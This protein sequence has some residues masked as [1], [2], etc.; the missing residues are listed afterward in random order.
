M[1]SHALQQA[2]VELVYLVCEGH[3]ATSRHTCD[4]VTRYQSHIHES[5]RQARHEGIKPFAPSTTAAVVSA[6]AD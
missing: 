3:V 6:I 1:T 4:G 5:Q 2:T